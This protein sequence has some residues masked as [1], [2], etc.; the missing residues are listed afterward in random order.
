MLWDVATQKEL[1]TILAHPGDLDT[2]FRPCP[3]I[4]FTPADQS[5][6]SSSTD[7]SIRLWQWD[8]GK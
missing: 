8:T 5:P 3:C 4:A 7:R 1:R 2:P 6:V